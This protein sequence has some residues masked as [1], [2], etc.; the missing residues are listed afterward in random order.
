M[1]IDASR[2]LKRVVESEALLAGLFNLTF[3]S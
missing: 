2:K 3:M 1:E